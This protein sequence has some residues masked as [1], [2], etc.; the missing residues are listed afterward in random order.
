MLQKKSKFRA[1]IIT[2]LCSFLYVPLMIGVLSNSKP[3]VVSAT[4]GEIAIWNEE[5]ASDFSIPTTILPEDNPE[6]LVLEFSG[7][8]GNVTIYDSSFGEIKTITVADAGKVSFTDIEWSS[9]VTDTD[10]WFSVEGKMITKISYKAKE[11]ATNYDL[12]IAGIQVTSENKDNILPSASP[13]CGTASFD[14]ATNTLSLNDFYIISQDS[15]PTGDF[16]YG[17]YKLN[18]IG[19]ASKL[20]D[21]TIDVTNTVQIGKQLQPGHLDE[22]E[23]MAGIISTGDLTIV[24]SGKFFAFGDMG[25]AIADNLT[26]DMDFGGDDDDSQLFMESN[27]RLPEGNYEVDIGTVLVNNDFN[28]LGGCV[29]INCFEENGVV[30]LG[31]DITIKD[32]QLEM[33]TG[34]DCLFTR[35]GDLL[36]DNSYVGLQADVAGTEIINGVNEEKGNALIQNNSFVYVISNENTAIGLMSNNT[37]TVDDSRIYVVGSEADNLMSAIAAQEFEMTGNSLIYSTIGAAAVCYEGPAQITITGGTVITNSFYGLYGGGET[38]GLFVVGSDATPFAVKNGARIDVEEG[39]LILV[40]VCEGIVHTYNTGYGYMSNIGPADPEENDGFVE[41]NT[42]A[43]VSMTDY[44]YGGTVSTPSIDHEIA[45]LWDIEMEEVM[46]L[47]YANGETID[48]AE[49]W[50]EIEPDTLEVGTYNIVAYIMDRA[51]PMFQYYSD[52]VEFEVTAS[53]PTL[54]AKPSKDET[55]FTYTGEEQTY[56]IEE[57]NLYT[58]SD[59]V[60]TDAGNYTVTVSLKDKTNYS[61]ADGS[62]DDLEYDFT[63]AKAQQ[64][65]EISDLGKIYDANAFYFGE[66]DEYRKDNYFT[67]LGDGEVTVEYKLAG[68]EDS[69]YTTEAPVNAGNYVL[70]VSVAEGTNYLSGSATKNFTIN[71]AKI[72]KVGFGDVSQPVAGKEAP[73]KANG[74]AIGSRYS[75]SITW[76]KELVDGKFDYNTV[77][78]ATVTLD[79]VPTSAANYS[80]AD[81]V[82]LVKPTEGWT[83]SADST[84]TKLIY[85]KTFEKTGKIPQVVAITNDISKAYDGTAI[86]APTY[87]RLGDG[88]VTIEY[89]VAGQQDS[90]YTSIAPTEVGNYV[91]KVT[92][93]GTETHLGGS[94]TKEFAI[95]KAKVAKPSADT[96]TFVYN[97]ENQTYTI[98]GSDLYTISNNVQKN[99]GT[100]S[101]TVALKDKIHTCWADGSDSDIA[102]TFAIAKAKVEKPTA[103]NSTFIYNGEDQTYNISSNDLYTVSGN[104]ANKIGTHK[105]TVSLNDT[106]N[107]EWQDGTIANLSFDFIIAKDAC[108]NHW[109]LIGILVL[110]VALVALMLLVV[111]NGLIGAISSVVLL[112][113]SIVVTIFCGCAICIVFAV[114]DI[115][116][117]AG[118]SIMFV[119]KIVSNKAKKETDEDDKPKEK[120]EKAN[121]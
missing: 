65:I 75:G 73:T 40:E 13:G 5:P 115:V 15:A 36:I 22:Y 110:G 88:Q 10:I 54:V 34:H 105:V 37:F 92:V 80:F 70:K 55:T 48:D 94:I 114:V 86:S 103:D 112:L 67:K 47:Y 43:T 24:G 17:D 58:I 84:G 46:Y 16:G 91:V 31:G 119:L 57:N 45:K 85:T 49:I 11:P 42:Y 6:Y 32:C 113:G 100:H 61:W 83:K 23:F 41:I 56:V 7:G 29:D 101:V 87:T 8:Y 68:E 26:I 62:T 89:K 120:K 96:S 59:N 60:Q 63:I 28:L 51:M 35:D 20:D 27:A 116:A 18:E 109:I 53:G 106:N 107:Y 78:T 71:Y 38:D 93:G 79:I 90:T 9:I 72:S 44:E 52:P 108:V 74:I 12:W 81:N 3:S 121:K 4:A 19:I 104:V 98:A 50:D 77:Y 2:S 66:K 99:A 21:L 95:S 1:A 97:G 69:T 76:D 39:T 30:S 64:V 14:P 82:T 25:S 117:F 33:E 111:K 102:F 118:S